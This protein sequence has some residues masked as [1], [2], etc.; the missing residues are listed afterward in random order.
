MT[1]NGNYARVDA[2]GNFTVTV[3]LNQGDNDVLIKAIDKAGNTS[4]KIVR[5]KLTF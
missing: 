1:V 3:R 5:V 4:E 2:N